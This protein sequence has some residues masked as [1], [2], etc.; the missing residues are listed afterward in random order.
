MVKLFPSVLNQIG[1][2]AGD[3]LPSCSQYRA[4][5]VM[6]ASTLGLRVSSRGQGMED[7]TYLKVL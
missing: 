4:W 1:V 6:K 3:R 5:L 7:I 2:I